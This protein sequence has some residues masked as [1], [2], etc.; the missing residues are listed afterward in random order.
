MR[1]ITLTLISVLA[2]FSSCEAQSKAKQ[3]TNDLE[4]INSIFDRIEAQGVDTKQ[5]LLYEYFFLDKDKAK[6]EK[7]KKD[8]VAQSY[9]Y[10]GIDKKVN[11]EFMLHVEK[12]EQHTRQSLQDREQNLRLM[13]AKYKVSSFDG[14]DVGNA[15]PSKPLITD[16]T[17]TKFMT[18]KK[19]NELFNLGIRLYD[20]EINDKAELV[21][22]ECISRSIKPDTAAYKLG[23]TLIAE[24]KID[25]GINALVQAT[26]FNSDYFNAYFNLGATCYDNRQFQKSIQ[27]YQQAGKLKPNDDRISYGIAASQYAL[28]Q[29]E[30]S[31]KN[32]KKAL[33]LNKDNEYARQLWQMLQA[34]AR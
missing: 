23:N 22:K 1:T 21:F 28:K 25:E 17:F 26:K 31:L 3:N 7:L 32:C 15:D 10:I 30:E 2:L 4:L 11:G 8:L 20:L 18:A 14:F 16:A 27:F 9:R 33:E 6:L 5:K 34:K 13:A 24:N 19:G 29:Y 12:A